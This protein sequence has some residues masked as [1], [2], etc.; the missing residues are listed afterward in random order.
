MNLLNSS[1]SQTCSLLK[2]NSHSSI[3]TECL[4][5]IAVDFK[6]S[7]ASFYALA[8]AM[9]SWMYLLNLTALCK[10]IAFKSSKSI[11]L[12]IWVNFLLC[13]SLNTL[14]AFSSGIKVL[15]R[16]LCLSVSTFLRQEC[17]IQVCTLCY[18][19]QNNLKTA[20]AKTTL[21]QG[22]VSNKL[23]A[24]VCSLNTKTNTLIIFEILAT[25]KIKM[26]FR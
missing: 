2:L 22:S 21:S 18:F 24:M 19:W 13:S 14:N 3:L 7:F 1:I 4:L 11:S 26:I 16:K 25:S 12:N 15:L 20:S 5:H 17:S 23:N 8:S 9:F 10:S 6:K